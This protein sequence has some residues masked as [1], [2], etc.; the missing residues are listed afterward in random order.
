MPLNNIQHPRKNHGSRTY[1]T[2]VYRNKRE[3]IIN[4]LKNLKK[5][6]ISLEQECFLLS[7]EISSLKKDNLIIQSFLPEFSLVETSSV[8]Q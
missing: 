8:L 1:K 6:S 5:L 4:Y 2:H 3:K 7:S